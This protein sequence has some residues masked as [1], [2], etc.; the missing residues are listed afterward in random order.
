MTPNNSERAPTETEAIDRL[1]FSSIIPWLLQHE[2]GYVNN[3]NDAG[4]ETNYGISKRSYPHVDIKGLTKERAAE[5]YYQD[6]WKPLRLGE[7]DDDRLAA[8]ILDTCV[9]TGRSAGTKILQAALKERGHNV[10]QDGYMHQQVI[11]ACNKANI[12][13]LLLTFIKQQGWHY[14]QCITNRPANAVFAKGW[15]NR[16]WSI[17]KKGE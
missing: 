4:G 5:I 9:N 13:K 3:P 12:D 10:P 1:R 8:K 16:A 7:I 6:W 2:G 14:A 15:H 17:Y 11:D